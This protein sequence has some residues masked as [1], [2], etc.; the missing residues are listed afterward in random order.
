MVDKYVT[1]IIFQ[2]SACVFP[3]WLMQLCTIMYR[4][5]RGSY[6]SAD[7]IAGKLMWSRAATV[8]FW[9]NSC[10][11]LVQQ[12][13]AS[14]A[15]TVCFWCSSCVLLMQQLCASRAALMDEQVLCRWWC[16]DAYT[17]SSFSASKLCDVY[18]QK[19]WCGCRQF[20][21]VYCTVYVPDLTS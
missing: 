15:A 13:C 9:C 3:L 14:R 16:R 20:I 1:L 11:L 12:L 19:H 2:C 7:R 10:V 8:C 18:H 6:I 17:R 5:C 4:V 21:H